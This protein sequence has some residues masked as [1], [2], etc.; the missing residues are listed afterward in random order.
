[1]ARKQTEVSK[2]M[3]LTWFILAGLILFFSPQRL[4]N[5][6]QFA[7]ARIF[8]WPLRISRSISLSAH[9]KQPFTNKIKEL[10][11]QNYIANLEAELLQE[12]QKVEKLSG[13]RNRRALEGANLVVADVITATINDSRGEL[14]INKGSDDGLETGQFV[15]GV[16]NIIGTISWVDPRI[17]RVK[18]VTDPA[19][20]MEVKIAGLDIERF[21]LEGTGNNSAGI[22]LLQTTYKIKVDDYINACKKPGYLDQPMRIGKITMYKRDDEKP[23][24]WDVTVEP[25]CNIEELNSV[26]VIIMNPQQ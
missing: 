9:T 14:N 2:G 13:L 20:R 12:R 17:A 5:K 15:L 23:L 21:F 24:F 18:L 16:N 4:T 10:Q 1:M 7:F 6:F 3:L 19:S 8:H 26:T 11:Y 25:A 22:D